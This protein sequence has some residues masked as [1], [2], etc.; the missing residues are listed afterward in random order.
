MTEETRWLVARTKTNRE[1]WAAENVYRQKCEYYLPSISLVVTNKT[2]DRVLSS[3]PLFP[4][5]L[6]VAPR[7]GQWKFLQS[8]FGVVGLVLVG[9]KPAV[10]PTVEIDKMRKREDVNGHVVLP[11][12]R[13]KRG[14][15]VRIKE[16][17]MAQQQGICEGQD[18]QQR[19][20]ILLQFLGR[21]TRVLIS[22][23]NL[24]PA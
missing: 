14:D 6:F 7:L 24:D 12:A 23:D 5:Y 16:G 15:S 20:R 11:R 4:G 8:T 9:D 18:D 19:Q 1:K 17:P 10:I 2:G 3:K 21:Q 22:S 13:F